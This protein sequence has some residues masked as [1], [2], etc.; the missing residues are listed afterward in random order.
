MNIPQGR[1]F[2]NGASQEV[3]ACNIDLKQIYEVFCV[4]NTDEGFSFFRSKVTESV[5]GDVYF[6]HENYNRRQ[7]AKEFLKVISK[8]ACL[9]FLVYC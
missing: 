9:D 2:S 6:R 7:W 8:Q 3:I 5:L 4:Q 1:C